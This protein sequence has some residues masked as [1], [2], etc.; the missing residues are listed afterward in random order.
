M[1]TCLVSYLSSNMLCVVLCRAVVRCVVTAYPLLTIYPT[2][3]SPPLYL[4]TPLSISPPLYLPGIAR[5]WLRSYGSN[6]CLSSRS[7]LVSP[8]HIGP[9][10]SPALSVWCSG[11]PSHCVAHLIG[12][13]TDHIGF[14]CVYYFNGFGTDHIGV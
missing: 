12:G 13:G 6:A 7:G 11:S 9:S 3:I 8:P 4:S 1:S 14:T 5:R 2:P 10:T